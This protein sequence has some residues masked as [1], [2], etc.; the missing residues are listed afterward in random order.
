MLAGVKYLIIRGAVLWVFL[1]SA[2]LAA[3]YAE[4]NDTD[5]SETSAKPQ[6]Q[7]ATPPLYRSSMFSR[8][9]KTL[10]RE[11]STGVVVK[12]RPSILA[13]REVSAGLA[14]LGISFLPYNYSDM[15]P[16]HAEKTLEFKVIAWDAL[17][18][19]VNPD[20][21]IESITL[22]DLRKIYEGYITNWNELG[23]S[24]SQITLVME[25]PGLSGIE[26]LFRIFAFS[27]KDPDLMSRP[28]YIDNP[29]KIERKV[30]VTREAIALTLASSAK[31]RKVKLLELDGFE[32]SKANI[33][34]GKYPLFFPVYLVKAKKTPEPVEKL[35]NLFFS[36]EVQGII[37]ESGG[38]NL[39]ESILLEQIWQE[40]GNYGS[41]SESKIP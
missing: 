32:P 25:P 38:I 40:K 3:P 18:I 2:F 15:Q 16:S 34:Q 24:D 39:N 30:E 11:S 10:A 26:S 12:S 4:S 29:S 41:S 13:I 9:Q 5:S 36:D 31:L 33:M 21:P 28:L 23:G 37:S 27:Q 19:A 20:N 1:L 35:Q 22:S 14:D 7:I 17:T 6:I 8:L